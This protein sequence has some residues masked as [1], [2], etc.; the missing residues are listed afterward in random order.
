MAVAVLASPVYGGG[1]YSNCSDASQPGVGAILKHSLHSLARGPQLRAGSLLPAEQLQSG[2]LW[3]WLQCLHGP[4]RVQHPVHDPS[5]SQHSIADVLLENNVSW[6]SYN[7][8]WN[9][10]LGDKY[11]LN[12]GTVGAKSDQYCNICNPFH[13][14]T[15]IMTNDAIRNSAYSGIPLIFTPTIANGTL[16]AVS[17][18]KTSGWVDGPSR[19]VQV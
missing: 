17:F 10:Y 4:L 3:R 9:A 18:V 19:F 13:Y 16:P 8:Q 11:Q 15:Q 2:L 12:Y 7:D 1:S 14:Q 5:T 6:K